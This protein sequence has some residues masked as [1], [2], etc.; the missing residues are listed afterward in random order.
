VRASLL[1]SSVNLYK[2]T[3]GGTLPAGGIAAPAVP[4]RPVF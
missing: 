3:G 4:P 2:A 1:V